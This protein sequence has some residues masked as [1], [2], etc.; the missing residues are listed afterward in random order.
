M[1]I[2]GDKTRRMVLVGSTGS[3]GCNVLDVV[4]SLEGQFEVVALAAGD[5]AERMIEQAVEFR[6][7]LVAM[8]T[9]EAA[10]AVATATRARLGQA[11]PE[12]QH[13][14][15][16]L[17]AVAETGA[18]LMVAA[19]VGTAALEAIA[20]SLRVGC[21]LALA[22]K[23]AMVAAGALLLELARRSGADIVPI[24]SEHSAIHQCL[25]AGSHPEIERLILTASGGPLRNHSREAMAAITP[26]EAL[27]HPTWNMGK[28]ISLDSATLMNK[29]FE[30]IEACHLFG[31]D[32]ARVSVLV[33]P[34]S[35]VHSLV[36]F[37]DGSV[38]A[39]LGTT[40]M[41]TPIQYALTYPQRLPTSR[42]RLKLEEVKTL[43]F[44]PPDPV[45]FP[46]LDLARQAWRAGG[47]AGCVLNAADEVAVSAFA[48][49]RISFDR[50]TAVIAET[51]ER[52]G[53]PPIP[54]MESA[55]ALGEVARREAE[56]VL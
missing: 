19:A 5:N 21:D 20:A 48:S 41:R 44:E 22:N 28:R 37:V 4:R 2:K 10:A 34:Q 7:R 55:L 24:D 49:G 27:R 15:E 45:R 18:E 43:E 25:R 46:C 54:D 51:L 17:R 29:G 38:V 50:I 14:G 36:E 11:A 53:A 6:P 33:H 31:L 40:D 35:I 16:G 8:R 30:I 23:E 9:A 42:T 12:V 3:I 52:V 13:G 39:Q 26:E 32:E 1:A 47:G 56:A